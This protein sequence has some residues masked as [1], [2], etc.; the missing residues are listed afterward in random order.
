MTIGE[1]IACAGGF[2]AFA[3]VFVALVRSWRP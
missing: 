3:W 1:G 2:L